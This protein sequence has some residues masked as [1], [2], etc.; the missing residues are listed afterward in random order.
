MDPLLPVMMSVSAAGTAGVLQRVERVV[1]RRRMPVQQ[2]SRA[3]LERWKRAL[4]ALRYMQTP[5]V[6][7]GVPH[8]TTLSK[9][10]ARSSKFMSPWKQLCPGQEALTLQ[11]RTLLCV[12]VVQVCAICTC[13]AQLCSCVLRS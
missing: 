13:L 9:S 2:N 6:A 1:R 4:H 11:S 3:P 7:P 5:A 8:P 10:W 12:Y